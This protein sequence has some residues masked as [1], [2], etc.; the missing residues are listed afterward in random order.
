MQKIMKANKAEM[1]KAKANSKKRDEK[2]LRI[3]TEF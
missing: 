3:I 1:N 2:P